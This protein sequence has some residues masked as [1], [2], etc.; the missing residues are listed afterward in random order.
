[1][2]RKKKGIDCVSRSK[3]QC[4]YCLHDCSKLLRC[5]VLYY[6]IIIQSNQA[7]TKPYSY[8][9][10]KKSFELRS[11]MKEKGGEKSTP[12]RSTP[13]DHFQKK[14]EEN[15]KKE[16]MRE[17]RHSTRT[18]YVQIFLLLLPPPIKGRKKEQ[19]ELYNGRKGKAHGTQEC[20]RG[21][22]KVPKIEKKKKKKL[23]GALA[24]F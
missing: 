20:K 11:E 18:I 9:S 16:G 21:K 2:R 5:F 10:M 8:S 13:F 23:S 3:K 14:E 12:V 19:E 6:N 1:M 4:C 24:T 17:A 7:I 22:E 15:G